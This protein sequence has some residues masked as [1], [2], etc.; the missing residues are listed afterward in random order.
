MRWREPYSSGR[1][2]VTADDPDQGAAAQCSSSR[3]VRWN[4]LPSPLGTKISAGLPRLSCRIDA[5]KGPS[6]LVGDECGS[7][8]CGFGKLQQRRQAAEFQDSA[9]VLP[10]Q[11]RVAGQAAAVSFCTLQRSTVLRP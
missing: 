10:L 3:R 8:R 4:T 1:G 6:A 7:I 5:P 2:I 11:Q 9:A